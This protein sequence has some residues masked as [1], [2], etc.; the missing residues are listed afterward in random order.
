MYFDVDLS[1]NEALWCTA[2]NSTWIQ[3]LKCS[4]HKEENWRSCCANGF[5]TFLI[6]TMIN[7]TESCALSKYSLQSTKEK[8]VVEKNSHLFSFGLDLQSLSYLILKQRR[9][10]VRQI[11]VAK[12]LWAIFSFHNNTTQYRAKC[13]WYIQIRTYE[14]FTVLFPKIFARSAVLW[15]IAISRSRVSQTAWFSW[16]KYLS[17]PQS[18]NRMCVLVFIV[19]TSISYKCSQMPQWPT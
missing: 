12:P 5:L 14:V 13:I 3:V 1:L 15:L 4:N 2:M 7:C 18:Y 8:T 16:H 17:G 11:Q 9:K 19:L 6:Q 10:P